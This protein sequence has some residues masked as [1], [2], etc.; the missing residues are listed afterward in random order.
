MKLMVVMTPISLNLK[1]HTCSYT[2]EKKKQDKKFNIKY[3]QK[4][5][6]NKHRQ[7]FIQQKLNKL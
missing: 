2:K 7:T 6:K 1:M 5:Y 3:S 4:L